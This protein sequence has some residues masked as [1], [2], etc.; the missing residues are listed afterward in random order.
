MHGSLHRNKVETQ[1]MTRHRGI[2][3]ILAKDDKF[4]E[5]RQVKREEV[6]HLRAIN[7]RKKHVR[8]NNKIEE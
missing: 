3:A 2:Y 1:R 5:K 8:E 6:E 7:G 4:V